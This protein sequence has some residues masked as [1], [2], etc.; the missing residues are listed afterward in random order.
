MDRICTHL[1]VMRDDEDTSVGKT[2]ELVEV[3]DL[4]PVSDLVVVNVDVAADWV[5]TVVVGVIVSLMMAR[6]RRKWLATPGADD[7]KSTRNV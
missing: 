5:V 7:T 6:S 2:P 4:E 1:V 3:S